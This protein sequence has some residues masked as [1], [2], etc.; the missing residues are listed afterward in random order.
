MKLTSL[1]LHTDTPQAAACQRRTE[2]E[3]CKDEQKRTDG[4]DCHGQKRHGNH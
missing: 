4:T 3:H 1:C 2:K